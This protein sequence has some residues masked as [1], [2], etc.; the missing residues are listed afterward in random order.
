[1]RTAP[2][3][4]GTKTQ[5]TRITDAAQ[6]LLSVLYDKPQPWTS[7]RVDSIPLKVLLKAGFI[8]KDLQQGYIILTPAG[9]SFA[10][11][12]PAMPHVSKAR[13]QILFML[14]EGQIVRLSQFPKAYRLMLDGYAEHEK[15]DMAKIVLT[16][17]GKV[18]VDLERSRLAKAADNL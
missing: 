16:S 3:S 17:L 9:K 5:Y 12:N 6:S 8:E 11:K 18:R 4:S 13:M 1:M 10:E 7:E 2:L 14:D 15:N